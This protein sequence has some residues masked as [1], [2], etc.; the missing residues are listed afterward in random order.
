ML[1]H[2]S[3]WATSSREPG[4]GV[5][6]GA[7]WAREALPR[8]WRFPFRSWTAAQLY[9]DRASDSP[10]RTSLFH[11]NFVWS[12]C[13]FSRICSVL[14]CDTLPGPGRKGELMATK[15]ERLHRQLWKHL[16]FQWTE[17]RLR[18]G[19]T[20]K[21]TAFALLINWLLVGSFAPIMG[22]RL[23]DYMTLIYWFDG[24]S[25]SQQ[26]GLKKKKA[27]GRFFHMFTWRSFWGFQSESKMMQVS[28]AVRLMPKPP[29]RVH[30]RKTN[31]SESGLENLSIAAWRRLPLTRP[32]ILSYGYL[33]EVSMSKEAWQTATIHLLLSFTSKTVIQSGI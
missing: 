18:R 4:A 21:E 24:D 30:R 20:H 12:A 10:C 22:Y 5:R 33:E 14:F 25:Q 26:N 1:E 16:L 3:L 28:A 8:W 17:V 11:K 9:P 32:S 7:G 23:S 13:R 29:A 15:K 2:F 31:L 27:S 19:L 6:E